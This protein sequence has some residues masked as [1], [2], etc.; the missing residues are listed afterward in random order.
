MLLL[1]NYALITHAFAVLADAAPGRANF[2]YHVSYIKD[3]GTAGYTDALNQLF[4]GTSDR[5]LGTMMLNNLGLNG[6]FSADDAEAFIA[7]N[8]GNRVGAVIELAKGLYSY[9][10]SD[11]GVLAAKAA[12][13]SKVDYSYNYSVVEANVAPSNFPSSYDVNTFVL[14]PYLD[15]TLIGSAANDVFKG[16]TPDALSSGDVFHGGA[17]NDTLDAILALQMY[18]VRAVTTGIENVVISAQSSDSTAAG[19]NNI[20]D[21]GAVT[22]DAHEMQGVTKWENNNSRADL[23]VED[24]RIADNEITKDITIAMVETDPGDVD[25]GVYFDQY[26]LRAGRTSTSTLA[27]ELLD[28]RSAAAGTSPLKDNPY[29]GFGFYLNGT[30]KVIASDAI[31]AAQTYAA[32]RDAITARIAELV[33]AGDTSL[34][35][36]TVSLG[37]EFNR[38]DT[39]TGKLVTGTTVLLT[40]SNG[41]KVTIDANTGWQTKNGVVPPSSGLHTKIEPFDPLVAVDLVTSKVILDDVGRGSNGGDLVIGGL[42]V[43]TTS[44]SKGVERF[45]IEVRDNSKLASISSTNNTLREVKIVNGLTSSHNITNAYSNVVTVENK[46]NLTVGNEV[47]GDGTNL[48]GGND[49]NGFTDVRLIDGTEFAGKLSFQAAIT[50]DSVAK[51]LNLVDTASNPSADNIAFVY[52]GGANDDSITVDIDSEFAASRGTL[53]GRE[54][55]SFTANGGAGNDSITV[56]VQNPLGS[57]NWYLD[58][59]AIANLAINGGEGNDKIVTLGSGDFVINAGAGNDVVFTDGTGDTAVW[60]VSS[61]NADVNN[62]L[63][64]A[65]HNSNVF[66]Y[67]G[68]LTVTFSGASVDDAGGVT[69]GPAVALDNGF[70]VTVNIP[71]GSNFAVNQFYVNQAIKAA[72]NDN[73]VLKNLLIAEDGPSNT[74]L[75]S[76]KVDGEVAATDLKISIAS[77]VAAEADVSDAALTAFQAFSHNSAATKADVVSAITTPVTGSVAVLNAVEGVGTPKLGQEQVFLGPL[78]DITGADGFA[79]T[80]NSIELGLGDDVAVLSTSAL[81]SETLVFKGYGLGKDTVVNFTDSTSLVATE[82]D[83]LDFTSYLTSKNSES[84]S[85]ASQVTWDVTLNADAAVDVNSVTVLTGAFT[86]TDTFAG[87][88]ASKLLAAINSTNSGSADYAGIV[89]GTLNANTGYTTTAGALNLVGGAGKA[90]VLV[91]NN[92]NDG[93]YAVFELAFN[94]IAATNTTAD[95]STAQLIGVV[96]FGDNVVLNDAQLIG[97]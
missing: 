96:D 73:A 11:A 92:L 64:N 55:F 34:A 36:V 25:Y 75:I 20:G 58:Q 5:D 91:E 72:I 41:G 13:V 65:A 2:D 46:G 17:G 10:G 88:T 39:D 42:S 69:D 52:S 44:N 4:A 28:T 90:V 82:I 83:K 68:K 76:S 1:P 7:A 56:S 87:L 31:D 53:S 62:L 47:T 50:S 35:G 84:G 79:E 49:E 54:D 32:L 22:V 40:D 12:Y 78:V 60:V 57:P 27:L 77:S 24:V 70:E 6:V 95:F 45:E 67:N 94:G 19:D 21:F 97:S 81:S 9:N 48:P 30:A 66:L 23:I 16:I 8:A 89:A 86:T 15:E 3:F 29:W 63:G 26:S 18:A 80:D 85:V 71:T 14:K 93:E 51:Y 43:G 59:K 33:S 61:V 37:A 74:L 38:Y